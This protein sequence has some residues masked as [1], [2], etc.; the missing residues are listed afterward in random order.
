MSDGPDDDHP[1]PAG[2]SMNGGSTLQAITTLQQLTL[3]ACLSDSFQQLVFRILN[4]SILLCRYDRALLWDLRRKRPRLLGISGQAGVN[5]QAPLVQTWRRT[6]EALREPGELQ[7]LEPESF[8]AATDAGTGNSHGADSRTSVLWVPIKVRGIPVAGLWL[9]RHGQAEWL[10]TEKALMTSLASAYGAAW[11]MFRRSTPRLAGVN[12]KTA[13]I[14]CCLIAA[15]LLFGIRLPLR[16]VAPCEVVPVDPVAVTAP[17]DGVIHRLDIKPGQTVTRGQV[18]GTYDREI[19]IQQLKAAIQQVRIISSR[20]QRA[21]VYSVDNREARAEIPLLEEQLKQEQARLRIAEYRV[22][23]AEITAACSGVVILDDPDKW[24]GKP[25]HTGE[26][27]LTIIDP[28]R[29]RLRAWL[30][31]G[32]NI[33]FDRSRPVVAVLASD[34]AGTYPARIT[35][36]A[37]TSKTSPAGFPA[38]PVDCDWLQKTECPRAGLKGSAILYGRKVSLAYWLLRK[39]L[40]WIRTQAGI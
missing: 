38:F 26:R 36:V 16:I 12:R 13:A 37:I 22:E 11:R 33:P 34:P 21:R 24:R 14:G 17:L 9:Q 3:E 28:G 35:F 19:S 1:I 25:V 30:P 39:P 7:V 15:L 31:P 4:R 20:L 40:A 18:L 27:I 29:T 23:K 8:P 2:A 6:V 5:P 10:E 32:D